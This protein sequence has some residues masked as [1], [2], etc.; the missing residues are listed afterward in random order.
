MGTFKIRYPF[1]N[2]YTV[3]D[4]NYVTLASPLFKGENEI[5]DRY[6]SCY[7]G[8]YNNSL[9]F[10]YKPNFSMTGDFK[11]F[12]S[13]AGDSNG[14]LALS[15]ATGNEYT[16]VQ[17]FTSYNTI[18]HYSSSYSSGLYGRDYTKI[19]FYSYESN[20][21]YMFAVD[22]LINFFIIT[23]RLKMDDPTVKNA[24][25]FARKI[26]APSDYAHLGLYEYNDSTSH[27]DATKYSSL[28]ESDD[29]YRAYNHGYCEKYSLY[30]YTKDGYIYPDIY[31]CD[32]GLSIPPDGIVRIGP[33]RFMKLGANI[34]LRID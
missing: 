11:F 7:I 5:G 17:G 2:G 14:Y 13:H 30:N 12:M 31:Y 9:V 29:L 8:P 22:K 18:Y 25:I 6:G 23:E 3:L 16:V 20:S 26:I 28:Y 15:R 10:T 1:I 19:P 4:G 21:T 32:G 33:S 27:G 34:F 24:S